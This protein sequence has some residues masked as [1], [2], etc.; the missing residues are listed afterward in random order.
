[1]NRLR[2][3]TDYAVVGLTSMPDRPTRWE[4]RVRWILSGQALAIRYAQ[5]LPALSH[6]QRRERGMRFLAAC[7]VMK[8]GEW[9]PTFPYLAPKPEPPSLLSRFRAAFPLAQKD[10]Q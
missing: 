6:Q 10:R 4:E 3:N 5:Q 7:R 9:R 2:A 8:M 1:M